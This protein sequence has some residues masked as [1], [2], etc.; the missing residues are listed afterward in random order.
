MI[1]QQRANMIETSV[2]LLIASTLEDADYALGA[3]IDLININDY[4][5]VTISLRI[6]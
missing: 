2:N 1:G 4:F 3:S 6:C 5:Q